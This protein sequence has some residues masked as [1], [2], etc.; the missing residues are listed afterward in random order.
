[1][2]YHRGKFL[3]WAFPPR[4][5]EAIDKIF[6]MTYLFEG[7]IQRYYFDVFNFNYVNKAVKDIDG[8]YTLVDYDKSKEGREAYMELIDLFDGK[9]ND[10]GKRKNA[11]SS[12]FLKRADNEVL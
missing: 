2:F 8:T 7:Q 1:L 10:I 3:V 12:T 6:V 5:F 11:L 9:Q 4:V